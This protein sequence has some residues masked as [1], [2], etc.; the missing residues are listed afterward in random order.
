MITVVLVLCMVG[1]LLLSPMG[2]L[3]S[4]EST[5][6]SP[7]TDAIREINQEYDDKLEELIWVSKAPQQKRP[8]LHSA[9]IALK[10]AICGPVQGGFKGLLPLTQAK[11]AHFTRC[12]LR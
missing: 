12:R 5:G 4:G 10:R 8:I 11:M 7:M 9:P 6:G 2:V 3:F 1:A